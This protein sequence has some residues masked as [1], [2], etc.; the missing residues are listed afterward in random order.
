M[1]EGVPPTRWKYYVERQLISLKN[2]N[3]RNS[4]NLQSE[5]CEQ[6][7]FVYRRGLHCHFIL[8]DCIGY[9][10]TSVFGRMCDGG[11]RLS[12]WNC[13]WCAVFLRTLI[14][15]LLQKKNL[16]LR[17]KKKFICRDCGE[18]FSAPDMEWKATSLS[19][20][21]P[22]PQCSS[23]KTRPVGLIPWLEDAK[24]RKVWE[25]NAK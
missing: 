14:F 12:F 2:R 8:F 9:L 25:A 11:L 3:L 20:P 23:M 21:Q 1:A 19:A 5:G 10:R 16:M 24:Y 22:C 17:G 4:K 6:S 7:V 18:K 15:I 13:C